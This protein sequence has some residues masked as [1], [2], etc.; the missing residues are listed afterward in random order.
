MKDRRVEAEVDRPVKKDSHGAPAKKGSGP[1][2]TMTAT[3]QDAPGQ[4]PA[5]Q[6][7]SAESEEDSDEAG[8]CVTER[9]HK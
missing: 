8:R 9:M 3:R 2:R 7:D 4:S 1:N 5:P 6:K